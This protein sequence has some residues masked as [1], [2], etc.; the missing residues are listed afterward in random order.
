MRMA[1]P[2]PAFQIKG[3]AYEAVRRYR[4]ETD[5]KV[6]QNQLERTGRAMVFDYKGHHHLQQIT[7]LPA[8][9]EAVPWYGDV[10]TGYEY[11]VSSAGEAFGLEVVSLAGQSPL[12]SHQVFPSLR[13]TP[14]A[15]YQP[16]EVVERPASAF[17]FFEDENLQKIILRV[18]QDRHDL[19]ANWPHWGGSLNAYSFTFGPL[20]VGTSLSVQHN[21]TGESIN[22]TNMDNW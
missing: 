4:A 21:A 20:T 1:Q 15:G 5:L 19:L 14:S 13:L 18:P 2:L 7:E 9:G 16:V 17:E 3:Q 8:P 22:L 11:R 6:I 10:G 12:I